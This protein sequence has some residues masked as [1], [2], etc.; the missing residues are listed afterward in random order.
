MF[1]GK[2]ILTDGVH[3]VSDLSEEELHCF[4]KEIGLRP[5]WY[6]KNHYD[7][8]ARWRIRRAIGCGAKLVKTREIVVARRKMMQSR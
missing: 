4:A 6:Q 7:M 2:V 5:E 8:T 1:P 3:L